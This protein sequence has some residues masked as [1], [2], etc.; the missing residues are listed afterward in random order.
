MRNNTSRLPQ[1]L[2]RAACGLWL[3]LA[4][5]PSVALARSGAPEIYVAYPEAAVVAFDH[6]LFEGSVPPGATLSVSG[7]AVPVGPDGLFIEW[8]PLQPGENVLLLQAVRGPERF[9]RTL[10]ITSRPAQPLPAE[11]TVIVEGS[12]SPGADIKVYELGAGLGSRLIS[13]AFEGSPGG[14][15]SFKIGERGP[16][17]MPELKPEDFPGSPNLAPGRYQGALVLRAGDHFEAAAVTVSLR[18]VDGRTATAVAAGKVSV[19]A[20][21]QL[22]VGIVTSEPVGN[23]VNAT[24]SSAR[25]GA[26][27]NSVLWLK[28]GMKFLVVGEEASTYRV[29]IA[30]GQG[31]NV[32]KDQLR[33]LPQGSALPRQYFSRIETRLVPGATQVRFFLPDR[34]PFSI[35]QTATPGDQHLDLKL[36]NTESDVDYMVWAFPD[37]L[38]RGV[39]WAQE[40]DG[41]FAARIDLNGAQQWG[42]QTFYEGSTLVLQLKA[43]PPISRAR[44]LQGRRILLDAGHGGAEMGAPGGLGVYEK[45]IVLQIAL[46]LAE[47]L[48]ARGAQVTLSRDRDVR[49]PLA[50]RPLLAEKI[51]AEV[52][53]SIHANALPDGVDPG[54]QRGTAV[55]YYQPQARALADALMS[56]LTTRMPDAGNDGIHYQNLALT[57]PTSQLSILV[58][59]AFMTDKSNLRLL[60]SAPG[61]ERL[62][63][64]LARGL[65]DFYRLNA[66]PAKN[67][68]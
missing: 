59:T 6:V 2:R 60:M 42:Y 67:E 28:R 3:V 52:L 40:A 68:K 24:S 15:A 13:V 35:Q 48:R 20:E 17:P 49:V 5:P 27:R 30:P 58:E 33:L 46:R 21:G 23:G 64:S 41:V 9:E 57:R 44:P 19:D 25:N 66:A 65:E 4:A 26:G 10:R 7:R 63:E 47:K 50:D 55:Y 38:V 34:V 16:F 8:L 37:S 36:Y 53:L 31:L 18:G 39:R 12:V 62:A 1:L 54:T 45:E 29:A 56:S 43:P 22:R 32:P 11:P 61:R 14:A 51:G